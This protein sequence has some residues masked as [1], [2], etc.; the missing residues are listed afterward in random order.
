MQELT[1][2][3]FGGAQGGIS[4]AKDVIGHGGYSYG[5]ISIST[6]TNIYIVIGGQGIKG[7]NNNVISGGYNGGGST[8]SAASAAYAGSGGGAMSMIAGMLT[9]VDESAMERENFYYNA[10]I[11]V[12]R[13][14]FMN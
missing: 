2:W 6:N 11:N 12:I 14:L 3:R 1:N 4:T 10:V 9:K 5:N 13:T 7:T 8:R